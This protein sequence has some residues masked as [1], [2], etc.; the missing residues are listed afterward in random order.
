MS[1]PRVM[2]A[3]LINQH[4]P[5]V[6]K[7]DPE[8][9]NLDEYARVWIDDEL[10]GCVRVK[11]VSWYQFEVSHLVVDPNHRRQRRAHLLVDAALESIREQDG[12]V[13]QC[14]IRADNNISK[15][16]FA[17]HGFQPGIGF[18][19]PSGNHLEIWQRAL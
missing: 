6:V 2:I 7:I 1:D 5:L 3:Q 12:R 17:G 14:T 16:I 8:E 10:A 19:G 18:T 13:A 11:K 4:S 9:I 15:R